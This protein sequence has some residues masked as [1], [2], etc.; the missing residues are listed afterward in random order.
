MAEADDSLKLNK[1]NFE[2]LK[3]VRCKNGKTI[4]LSTK[5]VLRKKQLLEL[6][7]NGRDIYVN[8]KTSFKGQ[9]YKCEKVFDKGESELIIHGLGAA[10]YKASQ[11]ALQ[12]K[13]IHYGTLDLDI[14]TC[15]VTL[16]DKLETLSDETDDEII[17][18]QSSAIHIRVFRK[19]PLAVLRSKERQTDNNSVK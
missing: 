18:R 9:L 12:L 13:E 1:F 4:S 3:S 10:V 19:V 15:T 16:A 5:H 8:N 11:L 6:R 7:K 14:K 17:N 2:T